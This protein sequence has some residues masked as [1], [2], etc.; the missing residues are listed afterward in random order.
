MLVS[1]TRRWCICVCVWDICGAFSSTSRTGSLITTC[2]ST[3]RSRGRR[4][5]AQMMSAKHSQ[6]SLHP[7]KQMKHSKAPRKQ[8]LAAPPPRRR[9]ALW[10]WHSCVCSARCGGLIASAKNKPAFVSVLHELSDT[11]AA[12]STPQ[13]KPG[14]QCPVVGAGEA[15]AIGRGQDGQAAKRRPPRTRRSTRPLGKRGWAVEATALRGTLTH[16]DSLGLGGSGHRG[17]RGFHGYGGGVRE[18]EVMGGARVGGGGSARGRVYREQGRGRP[19][20]CRLQLPYIIARARWPSRSVSPQP[21]PPPRRR[22]N[23]RTPAHPA[24]RLGVPGHPAL[25]YACS[26]R[27]HAPGARWRRSPAGSHAGAI[28]GLSGL[29]TGCL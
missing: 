6:Q 9:L 29:A 21:P 2:E 19:A 27:I 17:L 1:S 23:R 26:P 12:L 4:V 20:V 28:L 25:H 5:Y 11:A 8:S 15:W 7:S 18:D 10:C 13:A 14:A 22:K 24:R 3:K 16:L